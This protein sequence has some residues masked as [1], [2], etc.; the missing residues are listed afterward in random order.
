MKKSPASKTPESTGF[1]FL[2]RSALFFLISTALVGG[3]L[4]LTA[5]FGL[6]AGIDFS[7]GTLWEVRFEEGTVD[8]DGLRE[9]LLPAGEEISKTRGEKA[10]ELSF[11]NAPIQPVDGGAFLLRFAEVSQEEKKVLTASL[12]ARGGWEE[13]RWQSIGPTV[14]NEMRRKALTAVGLAVAAIVFFVAWAFR[15]MPA[16]ISGWRFGWVAVAA[17]LH[18]LAITVGAFALFGQLF[19]VEID[20][21]FVTALLVVFGYSVNDTIVVFDRLREN[22]RKTRG[23]RPLKEVA[24]SALN[25]TFRRSVFTSLTTLATLLF[26]FLFGGESIRWFVAALLVGV[27]AGT[28]SSIFFATP[29]LVFWEG[30]RKKN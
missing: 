14:G 19:G 12:D 3:S 30:K 10:A 5:I 1:D 22:L 27:G 21:L 2:G 7:G 13:L 6:R 16:G 4:A 18:D 8:R 17:L 24:N 15:G 9:I 20:L 23:L 11:A 28:Y 25:E 26:L 29:L